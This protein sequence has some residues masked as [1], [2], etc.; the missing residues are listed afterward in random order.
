MKFPLACLLAWLGAGAGSRAF[1]QEHVGRSLPPLP[2]GGVSGLPVVADWTFDEGTPGRPVAGVTDQ[3]ASRHD[4]VQVFGAPQFG[5]DACGGGTSLRLPPGAPFGFGSGFLVADSPD[6][7]FTDA[8]TL[9][10]VFAPGRD[11]FGFWRQ[12]VGRDGGDVQPG[13]APWSLS[14]NEA[15]REVAF[16]VMG[17]DLAVAS[18]TAPFPDDGAR[19][20]VAGVYSH[21]VLRLYVD[22]VLT[23]AA[24]ALPPPAGGPMAGVSVGANSIGGFWLTGELDRVRIT[25][26]ALAPGHFL[27]PCERIPA[28]RL[29]AGDAAQLGTR[30]AGGAWG[31]FDG[32]GHPDLLVLGE[33]G[34]P[35]LYRND[36]TGRLVLFSTDLLGGPALPGRHTAAAW[37]DMDGDGDLDLALAGHGRPGALLENMAGE[38]I[39]RPGAL[40]TQDLRSVSVT[41]MD[42]NRDGLPDVVFSNDA[43]PGADLWLNLGGGRFELRASGPFA[44][45]QPPAHAVVAADLDLDGF[46]D[47]ILA[48][49]GAA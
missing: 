8:F 43:A 33:T 31:D 13:A 19:H 49:Q 38:L 42:A 25:A 32:D 3:S 21:P 40:G 46:A 29:E 6:F 41:W 26:A 5:V 28:F 14:F 11:G 37:A 30:N 45:D 39:V 10:A 23:A 34:G 27:D 12:V 17:D 9:E 44:P 48:R 24:A 35:T 18:V 47:L 36:G 7:D 20:H 22:G 15:T 16:S 1:A 2:S 4:S